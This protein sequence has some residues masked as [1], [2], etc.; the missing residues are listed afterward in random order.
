MLQK[1]GIVR[2]SNLFDYFQPHV[3]RALGE[4]RP[5]AIDTAEYYLIRLLTDFAQAKTLFDGMGREAPALSIQLLEALQA[6]RP[7]RANL[8]R[9]LGDYTLY[10][11][12][13]FTKGLNLRL[14]DVPYY[15][16]LGS[17]AYCHLG[18]SPT[19]GE[20]SFGKIFK[21]L[22]NEFETYVNVLGVV[23]DTSRHTSETEMLGLYQEWLSHGKPE[24]ARRL[25]RVGLHIPPRGIAD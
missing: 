12:G 4:Y 8:L 22:G 2:N 20:V 1:S 19:P 14:V 21:E 7:Q 15:M 23:R 5:S 25:K 24:T 10:M 11:C 16:R 3:R 6:P 9:R 17:I 18:E 13:F